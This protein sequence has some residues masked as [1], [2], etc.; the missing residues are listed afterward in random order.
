MARRVE[1]SS[2]AGSANVKWSEI[3]LQYLGG[4]GGGKFDVFFDFVCV[5]VDFLESEFGIL[6]EENPPG[7][8]WN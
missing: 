2:V 3:T 4:G 6:G 5:L 1:I 8:S 7:D